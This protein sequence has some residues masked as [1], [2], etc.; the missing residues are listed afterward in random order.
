[1]SMISEDYIKRLVRQYVTNNQSKIVQQHQKNVEKKRRAEAEEILRDVRKRFVDAVLTV[2]S[3][4][5]SD[6]VSATFKESDTR[7]CLRAS[8]TVDEN[9]LRRESL[10]YMNQNLSIGHGEGVND[11]LALFTHGYTLKNGRPYGFWVRS[12][13]D[14]MDRIGARMHRDPN[15]F[16]INLVEQLN[17]EY[18]GRCALTLN[19]KYQR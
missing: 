2:V 4:F 10:H 19:S 15:P 14:S 1:M 18:E 7:G 11:I 9:A 12:G 5:Q 8:I 13:G 17:A 3:S 6:S 16:L